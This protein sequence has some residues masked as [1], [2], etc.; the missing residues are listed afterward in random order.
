MGNLCCKRALRRSINEQGANVYRQGGGTE[1]LA[2]G[3]EAFRLMSETSSIMQ[4][5]ASE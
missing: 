4:N 3:W 2:R 5:G 1:L